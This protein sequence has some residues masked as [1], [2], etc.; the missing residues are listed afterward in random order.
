MFVIKSEHGYF[1]SAWQ[2]G[3]LY[4]PTVPATESMGWVASLRDAPIVY[5]NRPTS[6]MDFIE[7]QEP[8]LELELVKVE[9]VEK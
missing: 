7:E 2:R 8:G 1:A 4:D 5:L 9:L 6:D 3:L